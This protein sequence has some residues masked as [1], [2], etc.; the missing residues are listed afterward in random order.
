MP[1]A[2]FGIGVTELIIL[3]GCCGAPIAIA[4]ISTAIILMV[5]GKKQK[6]D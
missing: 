1:L 6:P 2:L 4:A 3:I 5:N